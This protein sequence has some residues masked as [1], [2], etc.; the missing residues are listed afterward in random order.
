VTTIARS[1]VVRFKTT[2]NAATATPQGGEEPEAAGEASHRYPI[3]P[4]STWRSS[5]KWRD[6]GADEQQSQGRF[7]RIK[8]YAAGKHD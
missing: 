5:L 2:V 6:R 8:S 3:E 1:A 4:G 7:P